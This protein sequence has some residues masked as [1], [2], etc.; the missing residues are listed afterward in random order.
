MLK[1]LV[2]LS[3]LVMLQTAMAEGGTIN[4][5]GAIVE[6][7]CTTSTL[8]Q[9]TSVTCNREGINKVRTI[10]FNRQT[11]TLPYQLGTVIVKTVNNF[12]IIEVTYK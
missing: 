9:R 12:K 8:L 10:A 3:G 2:V 6:P 1:I 4:F 11:Q 7:A 5:S